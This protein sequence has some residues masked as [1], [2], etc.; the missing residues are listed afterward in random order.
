MIRSFL[1]LYVSLLHAPRYWASRDL[2][3]SFVSLASLSLAGHPMGPRLGRTRYSQVGYPS[4]ISSSVAPECLVESQTR[5]GTQRL[6]SCAEHPQSKTAW[7]KVLQTRKYIGF[8][9]C[10]CL[11]T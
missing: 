6:V 3:P 9:I 5:V 7:E 2:R 10:E 11:S 1:F 8:I 4:G